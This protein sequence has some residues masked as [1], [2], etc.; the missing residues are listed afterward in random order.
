GHRVALISRRSQ[1]PDVLEPLGDGLLCLQADVTE[2]VQLAQA[3]AEAR[4]RWGSIDVV[5]HAACTAGSGTIALRPTDAMRA[6]LAPKVT[7][8]E[9]LL[10]AVEE[11]DPSVELCSSMASL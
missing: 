10:A 3:L 6:V 5:M 4:S 11:D 7:G 2:P 8:T 1:R 9:V